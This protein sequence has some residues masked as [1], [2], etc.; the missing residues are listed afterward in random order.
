MSFLRSQAGGSLVITGA[1]SLSLTESSWD[2]QGY[3]GA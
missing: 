1:G 3:K 2:I